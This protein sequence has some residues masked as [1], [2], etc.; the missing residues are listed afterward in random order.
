M[1]RA[2][3]ILALASGAQAS[4]TITLRP[5]GT[6]TNS[7]DAYLSS[8][9]PTTNFGNAG[10][11]IASGSAYTNQ[12]ASVL[13]F[14]LSTAA[15]ALDLA[16]G[17]GNWSLDSLNLE[18][19]AATPNNLAFNANVAGPIAVQWLAVDS[20]TEG[21]INWNGASALLTGAQS[22][23]TFN[24][25]GAN[26]GTTS[27]ALGNSTGFNADLLAGSTASLYLSAGSPAT[28]MVINSRNF[29][30]L[31][32][33]PALIITASAV[34][35]PGRLVLMNLGAAASLLRRRRPILTSRRLLAHAL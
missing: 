33:R 35:E 10:A 29:T 2:L 34:P 32:N 12:F 19:T 15:T 14:D 21:G 27:Y 11:L 7:G 20:W 3:L 1:I 26:S 23:G 5:S 9:A 22:L 13:K 31:P 18:L 24:Y 6:T 17:V 4:T 16:Y 30:T 8:A 28:S 25:N